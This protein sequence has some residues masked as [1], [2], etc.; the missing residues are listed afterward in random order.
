MSI[1]IK[2]HHGTDQPISVFSLK[3]GNWKNLFHEEEYKLMIAKSLNYC[4]FNKEPRRHDE[5]EMQIA[6]Y[7]INAYE[8]CLVIKINPAHLHKML[9]F[10]YTMIRDEIRLGLDNPA[11]WLVKKKRS[12]L[13][14]TEILYTDLFEKCPANYLLVKLIT[15]QEV[16]LGYYNPRLSLMKKRLHDDNYSSVMDYAGAVGPVQVTKMDMPE[17]IKNNNIS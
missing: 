3:I 5:F 2:Q 10:F 6:G 1:A 11:S 13:S 16:D 4:V 12:E 17:K 8:V 7:H 14:M 15:G 9:K